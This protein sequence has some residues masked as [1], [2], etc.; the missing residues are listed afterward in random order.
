[1]KFC[2]VSRVSCIY[3][4]IHDEFMQAPEIHQ[5]TDRAAMLGLLKNA[6]PGSLNSGLISGFL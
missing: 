1:M 4:C 3:A 6:I 2:H 5:E